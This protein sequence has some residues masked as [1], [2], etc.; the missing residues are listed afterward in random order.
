MQYVC[1]QDP[2]LWSA[3]KQ[4]FTCTEVSN[5]VPY[6]CREELRASKD[7]TSLWISHFAKAL[8]VNRQQVVTRND[9]TIT[10]YA[11]TSCHRNHQHPIHSF[12]YRVHI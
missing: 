7:G 10:G 8:I 1:A 2:V 11:S 9:A 12:V 6:V 5:N 4:V 3:E